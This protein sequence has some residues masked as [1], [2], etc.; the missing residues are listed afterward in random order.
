MKKM[1]VDCN[2]ETSLTGQVKTK[3]TFQNL[4]KGWEGGGRAVLKHCLALVGVQ[5]GTC[6]SGDK[7]FENCCFKMLGNVARKYRSLLPGDDLVLEVNRMVSAPVYVV[8]N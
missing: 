7:K 8:S 4:W 5:P 1:E 2:V 3:Q 6:E